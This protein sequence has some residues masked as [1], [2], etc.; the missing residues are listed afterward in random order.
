[1]AEVVVWM[2]GGA[3]AFGVL[4]QSFLD[5]TPKLVAELGA[6]TTAHDATLAH[7]AAHTVRNSASDVGA[8]HLAEMCRDLEAQA[9]AGD[10]A[11]LP[12]LLPTL[13]AEYDAARAALNAPASLGRTF[14]ASG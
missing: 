4:K 1:V 10:L 9:K 6:A 13:H 5:E 8:R 11:A 3:G 7:R 12:A 14:H 2:G